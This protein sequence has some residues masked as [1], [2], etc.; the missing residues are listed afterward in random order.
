MAT[1]RLRD[2][3]LRAWKLRLRR[4]AEARLR[5]DRAGGRL[6]AILAIEGLESRA[7]LDGA[8]ILFPTLAPQIVPF[9]S[10]A[11]I[12]KNS[13]VSM[14]IPAPSANQGGLSFALGADAPAWAAIGR[15]SGL[16]SLNP[17]SDG[18]TTAFDVL[19][20]D[21][22]RA[23]IAQRVAVSV[24]S[25]GVIG[26]DLVVYGT[27]GSD[28]IAVSANGPA[29]VTSGGL[30]L[31][32]LL[33]GG[34]V[35]GSFNPAAVGGAL[36]VDLGAGVDAFQASGSASI[37]V[38]TASV[39]GGVA[40]D[41]LDVAAWNGT[42]NL[43]AGA[44]SLDVTNAAPATGTAIDTL[45]VGT[46]MHSVS[47]SAGT[48]HCAQTMLADAVS[49]RAT[50]ADLH[51]ANFGTSTLSLPQAGATVN[52]AG[53]GFGNL[54]VSGAGT[55]LDLTNA[56]FSTLENRSP[57]A[58][59]NLAN[60][61]FQ[62]FVNSAPQSIVDLS[63]AT[64]GTI[65]NTGDGATLNLAGAQFSS[66]VNEGLQATINIGGAN[67]KSL[68]KQTAT[69]N[70][71]GIKFGSLINKGSGTK[72]NLGGADF[73]ALAQQSSDIT[74]GGIDFRSLENTADNV[75]VTV[76]AIDFGTLVDQ[77]GAISVGA[78]KF[79]TLINKGSGTKINLG[80]ANFKSL[81]KQTATIDLGGATFNA[82]V[83][84]STGSTINVG[85][86]N[87]TALEGGG[88]GA[89]I[90]VAGVTFG[91]LLNEGALVTLNLGGA[92]FGTL[93]DQGGAVSIGAI[94]LGSLI[95][96]GSGTKINLGG[97]NFK[98]LIKQTATINLGGVQ[99]QAILNTADGVSIVT[100]PANFDALVTRATGT[101]INLGGVQL[102][103]L[104]NSGSDVSIDL[105][106]TTVT[107][108]VNGDPVAVS[109]PGVDLT[110]LADVGGRAR[111]NLTR[112]TFDS[113]VNAASGSAIAVHDA[114]FT[115][116]LNS[117]NATGTSIALAGATFQTLA[118][119]AA[120]ATLDIGSAN[121]KS[122]IKQTATI[123]LGGIKFSSLINKGT[124]TKINLGGAD[125][126]ALVEQTAPIAV[127]DVAFQTL[128]N[129][130]DGVTINVGEA[131]FKSLIKQTA[132]I[133]LGGIKLDTLINKGTG[134]KINLGGADFGAV[135]S[136]VSGAV[137][138][139]PTVEIDQIINE[140]SLVS[141]VTG[142]ARFSTLI[143]TNATINLGGIKFS[144]LINKGTGT[145]I[146]LAG[147][148]FGSIEN[149]ADATEI[150]L[151]NDEFSDLANSGTGPNTRIDILGGRFASLINSGNGVGLVRV[152]GAVFGA[153]RNDGDLV[154]L[155]DVT[156]G[157]EANVLVND[158][159]GVTIVFAAGG[160]DDV[161]VNNASC[162]TLHGNGVI[163]LVN[164]GEG[165]DRA[166]IGGQK[167]VGQFTGGFGDEQVFFVGGVSGALVLEEAANAGTDTLDF[168]RLTGGGI[169]ID[170]ALAS[171]QVVRAGLTLVLTNALGIENVVGTSAA[172]TIRGNSRDN[173]LLGA[174]LADDRGGA[175]TPLNGRLQNVLLDFD[176]R[177]EAGEH[178]YTAAERGA[179]VAGLNSIYAGFQ[180]AFL[181]APPAR[182]DYAT[183]FFNQARADGQPGGDSSEIDFGNRNL[184]GTAI[185]QV[186][187]LLG[188]PGGPEVT[189]ANFVAASTW[190]A[191][192]EL[193]HL[194]GLRHADAFG[195]V[196]FSVNTA[197]QSLGLPATPAVPGAP[198]GWETNSAIMATPALTGFT[199]A[200]LATNH[201]FSVREAV[202]LAFNQRAPIVPDGRLLV[203]EQSAQHGGNSSAQSLS[204]AS[205]PV[206]HTLQRGF[207][208]GKDL[209]VAAVN[210][211][212]S[213]ATS[214]QKDLYRIDGRRGD[215][216][217]LQVMSK[218]L[219]RYQGQSFDAYLTVSDA[220]GKVVAS[221]DD[222]FESQDPSIID[223]VLPADGS[224]YLEVRGFD[225]TQTGSYELF[226]WR[227]DTASPTDVGDVIDGRDGN[228]ILLGGAGED[229]L[230][231]GDGDDFL[232]G[233]SGDDLL[234]GGEGADRLDGG[235][236]DDVLVAG[237]T[238]AASC[239]WTDPQKLRSFV[240]AW[241]TKGSR[242]SILRGGSIGDT[243]QDVL[244]GGLGADWFL[245][246]REDRVIDRVGSQG[247]A[248]N[249]V[250]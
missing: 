246:G 204:L 150:T 191:A 109:Q 8:G 139:L 188:L 57:G 177:T 33:S 38:R 103:S 65:L 134:T 94:K 34:G 233:G 115:T 137:I 119:Y 46:K 75:T 143:T 152:A 50:S 158:G 229:I 168:S 239:I 69:I 85:G 206:P 149:L 99:I 77:G 61:S 72:I 32:I 127:G 179:I 122:L 74:V 93:V 101:T 76:G 141:I 142:G 17:G 203:A 51:A 56:S 213:I 157:S 19:V 96:K 112:V 196:G 166:V 30:P 209:V 148:S 211:I 234:V 193:G 7:L 186:N 78:I 202:K 107:T 35:T 20:S 70:L 15:T 36:Y 58:V 121:L 41:L 133:N 123:N 90:N 71:G 67:F 169:T 201:F 24:F 73:S 43:D 87:F 118:N 31:P 173:L 230:F 147:I 131:N 220:G 159:N 80:G 228:D 128:V 185:V 199:L 53:A 11:S 162:D 243:S 235:F 64:F 156:G 171:P 42:L 27:S 114:T 120:A 146:N 241:S 210:V 63:V 55:L 6:G 68:I 82:M 248:V 227:F 190:M 104:V 48:I 207:D 183:V 223:L 108:L 88:A 18:A 192:H 189:S 225:A 1:M 47:I 161:F 23:P 178:L 13:T 29:T 136:I 218:A 140:G 182:G 91:T 174:D 247:D 54:V 170:L 197:P 83:N 214:G 4:T 172:D 240:A 10:T 14:A 25:A 221:S 12:L 130:A 21:S 45:L 208:A 60:A 26:N 232:T 224:Y 135:Q 132:T 86:S 244:I 110:G 9:T 216:M 97:A 187:G 236:D 129:T 205:L 44:G 3:I 237:D 231:G 215:L 98:S 39:A 153:V 5:D 200:D 194:I 111:I 126:G 100:A 52:L 245:V 249:T 226:T 180:V 95:N 151:V 106:D 250:K 105:T 117:G 102:G 79:D 184:G 37:S 160:G 212:G 154:S 144:S 238:N 145:K 155:I 59:I 164:L 92:D 66:L 116:L 28:R 176:S 217:N 2:R 113:L 81:I 22:G 49:L 242:A 40:G 175:A 62:S 195:P 198:A 89:T 138:V 167:L 222:E 125:L 16:L 124:G 219:N 163:L 165:H 181:T 84:Q